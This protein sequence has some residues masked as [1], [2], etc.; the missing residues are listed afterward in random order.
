MIDHFVFLDFG[1]FEIY[2]FGFL[3]GCALLAAALIYCRLRS[4]QGEAYSDALVTVI[5][6]IPSAFILSRLSYCWFRKASFYG[7]ASEYFNLIY[8][9]YALHG[10]VAG[11]LIALLIRSRIGKKRLFKM[12]DAAAPA[13]S[14]AIAI[15][16]FAGRTSSE[17][18]GYE[19]NTSVSLPFVIWS[20]ADNAN[21]LWVGFFEGI[22]AVII[23]AL[24][25]ALF[26]Q[27]YRW[28]RDGLRE[29]CVTLCFM[30]TYGLSQAFFESLRGDSLF[31]ITL[32]FV[33]ID[34]IIGI[35]MAAAAIVTIVVDHFKAKGFSW[36]SVIK[37]VLCAAALAVAIA[38]EFTLNATYIVLIYACMFSAL[39]MMWTIAAGLFNESVKI[40][41][42]HG[43]GRQS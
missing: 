21:L 29:G 43:S 14:A 16:R 34:Q 7:H 11:I 32:G 20:E 4:M 8:G 6:A 22:F 18:G 41:S 2:W 26:L 15:G 19:I 17:E 23:A 12:L 28:H 33:R 30:L 42:H 39:L 40:R 36:I 35:V 10:A 38:C 24:T 5:L 9:G 3:I 13:L 31:M 37:C 25:F 27:K 1:P